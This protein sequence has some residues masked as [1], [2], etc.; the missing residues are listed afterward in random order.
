[1]TQLRFFLNKKNELEYQLPKTFSFRV[2]NANFFKFG[3]LHLCRIIF[4]RKVALLGGTAKN[5]FVLIQKVKGKIRA[6]LF[7]F[8]FCFKN[9]ESE[10][11]TTGSTDFSF[12]ISRNT[13]IE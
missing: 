10:E 5:C 13:I 9:Y 8:V 2:D 3:Q 11:C 12:F 6:K 7:V 4:G 1:M